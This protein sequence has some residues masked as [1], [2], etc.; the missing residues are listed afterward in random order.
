MKLLTLGLIILVF[1]AGCTSQLTKNCNDKQCFIDAA[2]A[3]HQVT[4]TLA[5]E[6]GT[7]AYVATKD[8][9]F[10]KTLTVPNPAETAEMKTLLTGKSLTCTYAN[11]K[12]D[13]RWV[14][15]V[16]FGTETCTGELRDVLGELTLFIQ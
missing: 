10:T 13:A 2:N 6:A 14:N 5:E 7:F 3:C 11:G 12:F 16:L 4:L 8:C 1:L 9:V 15:T